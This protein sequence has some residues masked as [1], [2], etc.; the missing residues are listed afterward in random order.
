[1][2]GE[3]RSSLLERALEA[4]PAAP[5]RG[6]HGLALPSLDELVDFDRWLLVAPDVGALSHCARTLRFSQTSRSGQSR[7]RGRTSKDLCSA[8]VRSKAAVIA[9]RR[10]PAVWLGLFAHDADSGCGAERACGEARGRAGSRG[11]LPSHR[12]RW[13]IRASASRG[14]FHGSPA[15]QQVTDSSSTSSR[16]TFGADVELLR[17]ERRQAPLVVRD[18]PHVSASSSDPSSPGRYG[19]GN[20]P[21]P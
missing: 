17:G 6:A 16:P 19:F 8:A 20:E 9:H 13:S 4:L 3:P 7:R 1:M 11:L 5:A 10:V 2:L 18:R 21:G 12:S 14:N 15:P